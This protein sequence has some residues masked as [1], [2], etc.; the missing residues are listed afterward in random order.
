MKEFLS[1]KGIAYVERDVTK[2][3]KAL[4]ELG[5]L[6]VM[7]TPVTVIDGQIVIGFDKPKLEQQLA[8]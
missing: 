8:S 4:D 3:E 1:Q 6:G 5:A 7:T 2:D